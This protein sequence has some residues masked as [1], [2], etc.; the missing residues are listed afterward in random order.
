MC[1][2]IFS[3]FYIELLSYI[4]L[5]FDGGGVDSIH[6]F[7]ELFSEPELDIFRGVQGY[8]LGDTKSVDTPVAEFY[9]KKILKIYF[10]YCFHK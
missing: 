1:S 3:G 6:L 10:F 2:P 4:N 8:G 5:S 9:N 7:K